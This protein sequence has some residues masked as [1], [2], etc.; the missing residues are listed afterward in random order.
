MNLK[1]EAITK[2]K[3]KFG[4]QVGAVLI[5]VGIILAVL[6]LNL[7]TS[8]SSRRTVKIAVF[9]SSVT[10]GTP[11]TLDALVEEDMVLAEYNKRAVIEFSNGEKRRAVV[12]WEDRERIVGAYT[13]N[14]IRGGDSIYWDELTKE[15]PKKNSY[16]YQMNGELLK[17]DISADMFGE[18]IVPGDRINIRVN[19]N[20]KKY[21]LPSEEEYRMMVETGLDFTLTENVQELLFSEVRILDMLNSEGE[22]IYDIYFKLLEAPKATQ[23][24]VMKTE[25][26]IAK[27]KPSTVL[28]DVTSEEADRFMGIQASSPKYLVT[29]L[30]RTDSNL[31]LNLINE[32]SKK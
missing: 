31:I 1:K 28:L 5:L 25:E 18:L 10:T 21:S 3:S 4:K 8:A 22:S 23:Q 9:A 11:V 2:N 7:I 19:Y 14:Y 30:P 27:T 15:T 13:A 16:L 20:K 17:L 29:L 6:V 12:L 32:Y 26:F 24:E